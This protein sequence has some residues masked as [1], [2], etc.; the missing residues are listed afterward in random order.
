MI[1]DPIISRIM[2]EVGFSS[3]AAMP[4]IASVEV[5]DGAWA[6]SRNNNPIL[7]HVMREVGFSSTSAVTDLVSVEVLDAHG[8]A[9]RIRIP[10]ISRIMHEVGISS[11]TAMTGLVWVEV[12]LDST[13]TAGTKIGSKTLTVCWCYIGF[14]SRVPRGATEPGGA[15]LA[16]ARG[17][18]GW[19]IWQVHRLYTQ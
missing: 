17:A 18:V 9:S 8:W 4:A 3:T 7:S 6:M 1:D 10:I 15:V 2:H 5:L 11:T 12:L 14:Q 13:E 19:T 16:G